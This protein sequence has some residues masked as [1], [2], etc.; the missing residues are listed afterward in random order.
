MSE[1]AVEESKEERRDKER[2][3]TTAINRIYLRKELLGMSQIVFWQRYVHENDSDVDVLCLV[4][5]FLP[6]KK[7][8]NEGKEVQKHSCL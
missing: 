2:Y 7:R 5:P 4:Q 1:S 6:S 8:I 3:L